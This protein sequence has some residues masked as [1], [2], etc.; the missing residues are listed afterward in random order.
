MATPPD[1]TAQYTAELKQLTRELSTDRTKAAREIRKLESARLRAMRTKDAE[2]KRI[3][4]VA[5]RDIAAVQRAFKQTDRVDVRT[6]AAHHKGTAK[7]HA[8][9]ERRIAILQGRIGS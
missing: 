8:A 5:D 4:K 1:M 3:R 9:L 2:I 6:L 7:R